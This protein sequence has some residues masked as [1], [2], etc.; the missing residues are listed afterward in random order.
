MS[1][2]TLYTSSQIENP[3]RRAQLTTD[4]IDVL[5]ACYEI[6]PL[7]H[8]RSYATLYVRPERSAAGIAGQ[9]DLWTISDNGG[10]FNVEKVNQPE[11]MHSV[12]YIARGGVVDAGTVAY[13]IAAVI[14]GGSIDYGAE[15]QEL[16]GTAREILGKAD[17]S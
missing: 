15:W 11:T 16:V 1:I 13:R 12:P 14:K 9:G 17:P 6:R 5:R 7:G 8:L 2:F 3:E 10:E 4:V